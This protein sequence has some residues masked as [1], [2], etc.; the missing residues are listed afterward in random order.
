MIEI[1]IDKKENEKE[2]A[3]VENGNLLKIIQMKM[4]TT[5]REGNLYVGIVKDIIKEC[6][7]L[8]LILEQKKIVLY[9]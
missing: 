1:L 2:I 9:I 4:Q 8:L 6:K 7:Q 5:R 3:L